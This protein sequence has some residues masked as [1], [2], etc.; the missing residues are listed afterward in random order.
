MRKGMRWFGLLTLLVV[1]AASAP[2]QVVNNVMRVSVPFSFA[3]AG[4]GYSAGDYTIQINRQNGLVL[5][6][7]WPNS[8]VLPTRTDSQSA[9]AGGNYLL[10]HQYGQRWVLRKIVLLGTVQVLDPGKLEK[11]F[12]KSKSAARK[13]FAAKID[14]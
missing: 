7:S 6:T 4:R 5:L 10:F 2:A 9:E 11:E 1:A 12:A 8:A 13:I 14:M 3:A